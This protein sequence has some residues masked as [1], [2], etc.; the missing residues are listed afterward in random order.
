M[1]GFRGEEL[2]CTFRQARQ[3]L[4]SHQALIHYP[5]PLH[6]QKAYDGLGYPQGAFPNAERSASTGLSLP[7]HPALTQPQVRQVA[8]A[9]AEA[10][11]AAKSNTV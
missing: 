2:S 10:L 11:Q 9:C 3:L 6:L 5:I 7:M 4:L 8:D 1:M